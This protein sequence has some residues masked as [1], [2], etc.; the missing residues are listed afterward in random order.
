M[1]DAT[2]RQLYSINFTLF[3]SFSLEGI[4]CNSAEAALYIFPRVSLSPQAVKAAE[5]VGTLPDVFFCKELLRATGICVVPGS[6]FGQ[7]VGTYHFR[8][9]ILPP[10]EDI[11]EFVERFTT[12]YK[13]FRLKYS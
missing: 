10:E 2:R 6:G 5:E 4:E 12:F 1:C 8:T 3:K 11:E 9:T 7:K 13:G